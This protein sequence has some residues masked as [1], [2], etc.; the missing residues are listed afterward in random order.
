MY[1]VEV[2]SWICSK[3]LRRIKVEITVNQCEC[4]EYPWVIGWIDSLLN[5]ASSFV[6]KLSVISLFIFSDLQLRYKSTKKFW[7]CSLTEASLDKIAIY[8]SVSEPWRFGNLFIV[9]WPF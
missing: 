7:A 3:S 4:Q 2:Y 1:C 8:Q 6:K 9:K 5:T